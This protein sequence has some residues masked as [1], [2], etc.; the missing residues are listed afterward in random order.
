MNPIQIRLVQESFSAVA[1]IAEAAA[2]M[3][4]QR[5]FEL[6]PSLSKLFK[7]DMKEQGRK[8]MTMIA[9]AV[10][11][12]DD[13]N[14]LVPTVQKLGARHAVYGVMDDDYGTVGSAL[15]WTLEQGLGPAFTPDVK[16]AWTEVYG[17]LAKTMIEAQ[18]VSAT[19][20]AVA[21]H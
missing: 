15:L 20:G 14:A 3:F 8:L 10:R 12:L 18:P 2:G 6:D 1:P 13:L 17:V 16:A 11:G 9:A 19:G 4:Y 5:L 21:V 7:G